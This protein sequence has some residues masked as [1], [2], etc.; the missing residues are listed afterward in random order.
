MR[1]LAAEKA[2]LRAAVL[3]AR[4]RLDPEWRRQASA[5]ITA[6]LRQLPEQ[7]A[8][9]TV[10]S[11]AAF[12]SEFDTRAFNE[13]VLASGRTLLLPRVD[14]TI[15]Q[16]RLYV[17]TSL[18]DDVV[19]GVWGIL[20]PDPARCREA[21]IDQAG[22]VLIPGVAF[23]ARGGRLGYGGGFYDRLLTGARA[24]LAK[25]AAAYS[26]QVVDAV[27]V[28]DRDARVDTLVT[29]LGATSTR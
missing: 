9:P 22:F 14:R 23:D 21:S 1:A 18:T 29:E 19:P 26:I 7:S 17:V 15:R 4:D 25:V 10:L 6:T 24:G 5:T 3:A 13:Q 20:E 12:R 27:P 2:G 11:Y 8:A 28:D 16:L